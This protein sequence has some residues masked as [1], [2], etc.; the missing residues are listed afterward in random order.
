VPAR[1]VRWSE[2]AQ[3]DLDDII[4]YIAGDSSLNAERVLGRLEDQATSLAHFAER[5]R[6]IPELA[7]GKRPQRSNWRELLVRPWRIVY[8]IEADLVLVL[9]VVDGRRDFRAWLAGRSAADLSRRTP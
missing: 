7:S 9:A 8:A 4:D 3:H 2:A 6:R 5:G 1:A